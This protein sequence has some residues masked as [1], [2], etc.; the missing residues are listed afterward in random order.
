MFT[1]PLGKVRTAVVSERDA[2]ALR[3]EFAAQFSSAS[4]PPETTEALF[5][6]KDGVSVHQCDV[7]GVSHTFYTNTKTSIPIAL[8]SG[9]LKE[10]IP[11]VTTCAAV[12]RCLPVVAVGDAVT[13]YVRDG[14]HVMADRLPSQTFPTKAYT[15]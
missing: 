7:K 5:P 14:A 9:A 8:R 6:K 4:I 12:P 2:K 15:G 13:D 10:L 11:T 1:K 3:A